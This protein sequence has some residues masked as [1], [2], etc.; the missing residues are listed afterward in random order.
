MVDEYE[1]METLASHPDISEDDLDR[2]DISLEEKKSTNIFGSVTDA[3]MNIMKKA[4]Q[5]LG[6]QPLQYGQNNETI[7]DQQ[8]ASETKL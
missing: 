6:H 7:P 1:E 4:A 3:V 8:N 2:L 5:A